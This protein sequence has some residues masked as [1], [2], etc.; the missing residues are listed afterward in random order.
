MSPRGYAP[1]CSLHLH[2]G[3]DCATVF[4][5]R[6][7]TVLKDF[8]GVLIFDCVVESLIV[9]LLSFE[10]ISILFN[11]PTNGTI[12]VYP[13]LLGNNQYLLGQVY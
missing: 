5:S 10:E 1:C 9:N 11:D 3:N 12:K 2:A 8:D 4:H 6:N 7:L 13:H